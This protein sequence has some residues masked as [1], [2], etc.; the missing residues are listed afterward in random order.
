MIQAV[1]LSKKYGNHL[2]LNI[3]E[4]QIP[5]GQVFGL[6][7]NNGA[8]KT[9]FFN[10]ILDLIQ[11]TSGYILNKEENVTQTTSW[12]RHTGAF[13][14]ESFLIGYLTPEE[15]FN[16]V[17][18]LQGLNSKQVRAFLKETSSVFT[19]EVLGKNKYIRDLSKGNKKKVGILAALVGNPE[20]I[21]LD[22]P[23]ANLD[24]TTQVRMKNLI[25]QVAAKKETT[26][27]VSSHDL[28]HITEISDRI[29]L[30]E[31]GLVKKDLIK[32]TATLEELATYFSV[33]E[34]SRS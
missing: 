8:G 14:D 19:E 21:I 12:K 32:T 13:I 33:M 24:P 26:I 25:A 10:L 17:G 29:V 5:K 11:P 18:E 7:G 4:L 16:F 28:G 27:L 9:T 30:L 22:E 23:F 2:A 15:Y 31:N 1:K 34:N 6:V 20:V 3:E